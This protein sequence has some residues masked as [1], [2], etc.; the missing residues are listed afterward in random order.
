MSDLIGRTTRG[1]FRDLMTDSTVGAIDAAFQDERFAP[2]HDC[3]YQDSSVRRVTTQSY[4]DSVD[5]S[6][7]VHISRF[8]NVAERLLHG[9]DPKFTAK[10]WTL[11]R[12]DGYEVDESS[13]QISPIGPRISIESLVKVADP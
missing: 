12:R 2:H 9:W 8:L 4:L 6:N 5:W 11:L 7:P 1:I 13:G 10:F 3:A